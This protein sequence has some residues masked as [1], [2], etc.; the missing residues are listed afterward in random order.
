MKNNRFV[1]G[2][3]ALLLMTAGVLLSCQEDPIQTGPEQ[4]RVEIVPSALFVQ[5]QVIDR[6]ASTQEGT[7]DDGSGIS[8]QD[9]TTGGGT[10]FSADGSPAGT[11]AAGTATPGASPARSSASTA[12]SAGALDAAL[13][14]ES[15]PATTRKSSAKAIIHPVARLN[16]LDGGLS[17]YKF[18]CV[19]VRHSKNP[20]SV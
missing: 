6:D 18:A 4:E 2:S 8:Q 5:G 1:W 19:I 20:P 9:A 12:A 11:S 3:T 13:S 16:G 10:A 15:A 7:A 17:T 14:G